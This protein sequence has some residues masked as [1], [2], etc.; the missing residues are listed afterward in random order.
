ML[1]ARYLAEDG[2]SALDYSRL[3]LLAFGSLWLS[4]GASIVIL[5]LLFTQKHIA[6]GVERDDRGIKN[7]DKMTAIVVPIFNENPADVF[8]RVEALSKELT[9][10]DLGSLFAI[11]FLSDTSC[12]EVLT[13][14]QL[15]FA[16][17]QRRNS[18]GPMSYYRHRSCNKGRKAGNI[19]EFLGRCGGAYEFVTVLDADSL[20]SAQ[21]LRK[22]VLKM[23]REPKLGLLQTLPII[24][25][26]KSL[27]GRLLEFS[28]RLH[29][30]AFARGLASI[31]G[32]MGPYWGHNAIFRSRAFT[33]NCGL[34]QLK[35]RKPLGGHILSH[36]TVE[37]ALLVRGGWSVRC[38]P[39]LIGSYEGAP[40]TL[41]GYAARDRRWCQGNLQHAKIIGARGL[42][43]WSR[44]SLALGIAA[45]V[46]APLWFLFISLSIVA[47]IFLDRHQFF[48]E[49]GGAATFPLIGSRE[50]WTLVIGI[51][52]LLIAPQILSGLEGFSRLK[53]RGVRHYYGA[54]LTFL[55][56]AMLAPV[57][58]MFQCRAILDIL[59]GRDC[60]WTA[61]HRSGETLSFSSCCLGTWWITLFGSMTLLV[62][63][64]GSGTGGQGTPLLLWIL[65]VALPL[66]LAP[67]L[68][69]LTALPVSNK[70]AQRLGLALKDEYEGHDSL[71]SAYKEALR[72]YCNY[73]DVSG[74]ERRS[75]GVYAL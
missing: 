43:G 24:T 7:L 61:A 8:A 5:G 35:G 23:E 25:G 66:L 27:L 14:E 64:L 10:Q 54:V 28:S 18:S 22:M 57:M 16:Y 42:K 11:H 50:G 69:W 55:I 1:W 75:D 12:D 2:L 29:S 3:T 21:V 58:M 36:D 60:G 38:D 17:F 67:F 13:A 72:D 15:L 46:S 74:V 33:E 44:F 9:K 41:L 19:A 40:E 37:A 65:P 32:H 68:V 26:Q 73:K 47:P 49:Y 63:W 71:T 59:L 39:E 34:P 52:V 51:A 31:Q 6:K 20:M 53:N 62:L 45:Y 48:S 4:W 30:K 56:M 70:V